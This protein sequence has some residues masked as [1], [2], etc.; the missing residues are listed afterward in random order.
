MR[1]GPLRVALA[2]LGSDSAVVF[3]RAGRYFAVGSRL[4]ARR[5]ASSKAALA[6]SCTCAEHNDWNQRAGFTA[7]VDV[8]SFISISNADRV[9][10][11][12]ECDRRKVV[13]LRCVC[14]KCSYGADDGKNAIP[15]VLG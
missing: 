12:D 7:I 5:L 2:P 11:M 6:I 13:E 14:R 15:G 8:D 4:D 1:G 10:M 9:G 3:S